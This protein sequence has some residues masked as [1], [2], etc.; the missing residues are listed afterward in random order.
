[1]KDIGRKI[2]LRPMREQQRR[3]QSN[4]LGKSENLLRNNFGKRSQLKKKGSVAGKEGGC[5]E[6]VESG[7]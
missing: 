5:D 4:Y 3:P 7:D 1:M 6:N 2:M